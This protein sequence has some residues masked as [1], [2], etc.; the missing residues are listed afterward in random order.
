M[1]KRI[2]ILTT[3]SSGKGG[4]ETVIK[5]WQAKYPTVYLAEWTQPALTWGDPARSIVLRGNTLAKLQQMHKFI[6]EHE[7]DVVLATGPTLILLAKLAALGSKRIK[8][9]S[10]IH[11]SLD[12]PYITTLKK[13]F[14]RLADF[15]LAIAS[16]IEAQLVAVGIKPTK[17]H[18]IYNPIQ[19]Q[20]QTI[21]PSA[22]ATLELVY[23]GRVML[24]GQKNLRELFAG[25]AQLTL[26][27][28]L[29]IFGADAKDVPDVVAELERLQI[30]QNVE[31][32]GWHANPWAHIQTA[33][34]LV[35]TSTYEGFP[36][37]LCEAIS[38]GLPV[39][40]SQTKTGTDDIVV[41]GVNGYMYASGA[42]AQLAANLAKL[43][44][45]QFDP[46]TIKKSLE[47]YYADRYFAN[48]DTLF[49]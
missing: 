22:T 10:W 19:R 36:L 42:P 24:A 46:A 25:L 30:S 7:I 33:D 21:Q 32:A 6:I 38:Y 39:V 34:G 5:A 45:Q 1:Q 15:H 4:T 12:M 31:F 40:A 49:D 8:I 35:L 9:G 17:I 14:L 18:T 29:R 2:L 11:F 23:V 20:T 37:V 3:K 48:I 26:P 16:A 13:Q 41:P 43:H 44:A 47:P 28:H 27:W